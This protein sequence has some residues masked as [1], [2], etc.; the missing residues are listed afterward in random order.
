M[1]AANGTIA[2]TVTNASGSAIADATVAADSQSNITDI[3]GNYTISIGSGTYTLTASATGYQSDSTSVT[4][5]SGATVTQNFALTPSLPP[6]GTFN[7]SGFKIDNSTGMG[8]ANWNITLTK[9]DNTVLNNVTDSNGMY[10]FMNLSNGTYTITEE[11]QPGWTNVSA[12]PMTVTITGSDMMNQNF[13]NIM[14]LPPG[15]AF[16]ISGFKIDNSTGMGLANWNITL[17]KPDNTVL[18][19]VTDS[20]G[21]YQ[22]MN[23]PNGTYTVTE[24]MQPGWTN[25]S[26]MPMDSHHTACG[27]DEPELH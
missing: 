22:F 1:V 10:Q 5:T 2:G 8:L 27:Q 15:G 4:V 14:Q 18:N 3:N 9:P 17:T 16:N 25:V 13:T 21:M 11:M 20:S 24:Q 12:M 26:A 23:L 6:E 19:N 7:I